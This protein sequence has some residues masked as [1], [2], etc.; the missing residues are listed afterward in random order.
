AITL[1]RTAD[2]VSIYQNQQGKYY[3]SD[4]CHT[5]G[6]STDSGKTIGPGYIYR[7]DLNGREVVAPLASAG[8]VLNPLSGIGVFAVDM[9]QGD[10]NNTPY[11]DN[12]GGFHAGAGAFDALQ[13]NVCLGDSN[14]ISYTSGSGVSSS[15]TTNKGTEVS[16]P[17]GSYLWVWYVVTLNDPFGQQFSVEYRYRFYANEVDLLTKVKPCPDGTCRHDPRGPYPYLKMPKFH[18]TVT[19]PGS[20]YL[21]ETCYDGSG[22]VI[23]DAT[24]LDYPNGSTVNKHCNGN[25]RDRI[26]IRKSP[27]RLPPFRIRGRS[28]RLAAFGQ[29][30][31][32]YPW[33]SSGTTYGLDNWGKVGQSRNH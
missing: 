3:I 26:D 11:T 20:D 2:G 4:T 15:V 12:N 21:N 16:A 7:V 32:S 22:G 25:S 24:Q 10:P 1:T 6:T 9:Y 14:N 33:E 18:F 13:G 31:P 8:P 29:D 19:G 23:Q 30:Q 17:A 27:S 5:N 28:Q